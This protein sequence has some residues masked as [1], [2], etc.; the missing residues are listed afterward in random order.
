MLCTACH[1]EEGRGNHYFDDRNTP[2]PAL[3]FLAERLN[4]FEADQ[5]K[6]AANLL[7]QGTNLKSLI[8][9]PP[10]DADTYTQFVKQIEVM[11]D[12]MRKGRHGVKKN[13]SSALEPVN[14]PSWRQTL[15]DRQIDAILADLIDLYPFK[16]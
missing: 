8:A 7:R 10:F 9:K 1:G 13:A 3:R 12:V 6:T 14:M 15:T 16:E 2:I 5:A 4:L 11:R